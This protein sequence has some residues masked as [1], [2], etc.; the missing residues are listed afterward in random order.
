[1]PGKPLVPG[2]PCSP[3]APCCPLA[4]CRP[5]GPITIFGVVRATDD[6]TGIVV[7]EVVVVEGEAVVD[8]DVCGGIAQSSLYR[9]SPS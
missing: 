2:A 9:P 3:G 7:V 1:M 4:P 8:T 6:V 5:G